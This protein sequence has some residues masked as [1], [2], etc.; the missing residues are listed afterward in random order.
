M[1]DFKK[2]EIENIDGTKEAVDLAKVLGNALYAQA[3]T[4]EVA[5]LARNIWK[6]GEVELTKEDKTILNEMVPVLFPTYIVR[7]ALLNAINA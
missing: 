4:L 3:K 7:T 2:I 1:V 6:N 5:E